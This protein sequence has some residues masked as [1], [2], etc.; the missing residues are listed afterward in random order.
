MGRLENGKRHAPKNTD[1]VKCL[2][3]G[4]TTTWGALDPI[5]QLALEEGLDTLPKSECLLKPK[6]TD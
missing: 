6:P 5:Q 1:E 3:H 2:E 4:I